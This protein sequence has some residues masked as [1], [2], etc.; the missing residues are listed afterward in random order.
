MSETTGQ[1]IKGNHATRT[2]TLCD[3]IRG[4]SIITP[5]LSLKIRNHSPDGFSWGYSGSGPAQL[6]LAILLRVFG[7]EY[8]EANYQDFKVGVI[9]K[10]PQEDFEL[11]VKDVIGWFN[12]RSRNMG[13]KWKTK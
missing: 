1:I 3:P 4:N 5:Q 9:A 13:R 7:K 12:N 6:A 11:P 8:A 10:L 2:I